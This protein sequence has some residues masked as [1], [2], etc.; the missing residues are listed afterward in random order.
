MRKSLIWQL[1]NKS[2]SLNTLTP[3]HIK[4]RKTPNLIEVFP[5][6]IYVF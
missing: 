3:C 5:D 1:K 2:E 6:F 4:S